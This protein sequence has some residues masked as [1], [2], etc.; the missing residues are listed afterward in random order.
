MRTVDL[1]DKKKRGKNLSKKEI[2]FLL[3][4]YIQ[5]KVED[6]QMSAFLMAVYFNGMSDEELLNF[7][8]NMKNS[9][10]II[11]LK[12]SKKFLVD[13]HS[14]GG[15]G[16][17]ITIILSPI[18]ASLGM[19]TAK[20][21]GKGL[22]H[23][24]GTIDKFESLNNFKF[25]QNNKELLNILNSTG[26]GLMGYSEKVVPLDKKIYSLRDV[27]ATVDSIPLIA[28]SIMSK[29]LAVESDIIVLDVKAGDGAFMKNISQAEELSKR[30]VNIGKNYGR[31]TIAII[32]E[33]DEPL[34]YNIGNSL[35]IIESID[36]LNGNFSDDIKEVVYEI[37][38]Q[39]LLFRKKVT[40][41]SEA[42]DIIDKLIESKKP[43]KLLQKFLNLSGVKDN[44]TENVNLIKI[45]DNKLK[46]ISNKEGYIN[47]ISA[48]KIGEAAMIIGAGRSKKDD[49]I[50]YSVG[51]K[52][53][54]KVLDYVKKG[55]ILAEI[56]YN[57]NAKLS[58]SKILVEEAFLIEDFKKNSIK[59]T[60]I[61]VIQ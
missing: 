20:L 57:D 55:E 44:V 42:K 4:G 3:D 39:I 48:K 59:K 58:E 35:E 45:A 38:Y 27:T 15:V 30:M 60:I 8:I 46:I 17:K 52:L 21:S 28:S 23:T 2:D 37:I 53:H 19:G 41:Y 24:G 18:L 54:K 51:I 9:G 34:G 43:L 14:T 36:S 61:K 49:K 11:K 29:K 13:K 56:Y 32:S 7:T 25:S 26:I 40:S 6:Y 16:D 31:K 50:D 12:S 10:E 33:M 47:K 5:G 22:G 1:I